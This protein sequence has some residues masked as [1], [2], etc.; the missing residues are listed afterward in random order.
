MKKANI[1]ASLLLIAFACFYAYLTSRLPARNLPNTL[2]SDF[3]PWL[4]V[5]VLFL[6]S[7]W[8]LLQSAVRGTTENFNPDISIKEGLS[9]V[10]LTIFVYVYVKPFNFLDL[11]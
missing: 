3:M 7:F 9:I 8:L 4:L 10:F 5:T 1:V 2:G 11:S 6:L